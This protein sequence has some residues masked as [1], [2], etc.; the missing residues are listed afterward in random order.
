MKKFLMISKKEDDGSF[1]GFAKKLF[2]IYTVKEKTAQEVITLIEKQTPDYVYL[3]S[4]KPVSEDNMMG[5]LRNLDSNKR[6][7]V[8]LFNTL[9]L[10]DKLVKYNPFAFLKLNAGKS[11][12]QKSIK[13]Y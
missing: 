13:V 1:I 9:L 12:K 3:D 7:R 10:K 5:M 11:G 8:S 2:D 4:L 6:L